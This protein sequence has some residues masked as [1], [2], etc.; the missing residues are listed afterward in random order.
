MVLVALLPCENQ[1]HNQN[2]NCFSPKVKEVEGLGNPDI[3]LPAMFLTIF[4]DISKHSQ[5]R[6]DL[7]TPSVSS[8]PALESLS[9]GICPPKGG[10]QEALK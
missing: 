8:D 3:L 2:S 5:A 4:Q 10:V 9:S 6:G 7:L 1:S